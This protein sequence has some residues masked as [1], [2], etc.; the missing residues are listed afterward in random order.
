LDEYQIQLVVVET[1][2]VL[3]KLLRTDPAW[4]EAYRDDMAVVFT[5]EAALR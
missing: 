2:S 4:Q 5:R 1:N 3:D